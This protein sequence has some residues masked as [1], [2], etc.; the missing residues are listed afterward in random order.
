MVTAVIPIAWS[1][2]EHPSGRGVGGAILALLW[3]TAGLFFPTPQASEFSASSALTSE[4]LSW[5]Q[6]FPT[7]ES[8]SHSTARYTQGVLHLDA[9]VVYTPG[10]QAAD[11]AS[12][13]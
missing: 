1:H 11:L 9:A 2:I 5:P 12:H 10:L 7:P 13:Y 8:L 3:L 4:C 6:H